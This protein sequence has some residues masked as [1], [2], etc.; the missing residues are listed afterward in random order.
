MKIDPLNLDLLYEYA[1]FLF[2]NLLFKEAITI[3]YKILALN[4][5]DGVAMEL[6]YKSY[7]KLNMLKETLDIGKQLLAEK[8]TDIFLLQE[9]AEIAGKLNNSGLETEYFNRILVIQPANTAALFNKA[10]NYLAEN[11]LEQATKIFTNLHKEGQND[12]ITTIYAGIG[13]VM[14]GNYTDAIKLL[15]PILSSEISDKT[16]INS[17]LGLLYLVYSLCQSSS[18]LSPIKRWAAKINYENLKQNYQP[19]D[20]QKVVFITEFIINQSLKVVQPSTNARD[21]IF[22][23]TKAYLPKGYFTTNSNSTIAELWF[24]IGNKQVDVKNLSDAVNSFQKAIDLRPNETK[25]QQKQSEIN[26][27]LEGAQNEKSKKMK[28]VLVVSFA[29]LAII[30]V[31]VFAFKFLQEK[32]LWNEAKSLNSTAGYTKYLSGYPN[33]KYSSEA[34]DSLGSQLLGLVF[35]KGGTFLMGSNDGGDNEKP[36]HTVTLSDFYICKY[37]VTQALWESIMGFNP[38]NFK[39]ANLPVE[40]VSWNDIQEFLNKLSKKTGKIFNLPTEAQWEYAAGGGANNRTKYAG[41]NSE[42]SLKDYAWI[43]DN[44]NNTTHPVG[45]KKPNGLGLYDMSGNVWE[46]CS[47][48]YGDNYYANSP[49]NNP[50]G[51]GTGSYRVLRGGGWNGFASDC[52]VS[53]RYGFSPDYRNSSFGFRLVRV[54]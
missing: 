43:S 46:R 14:D 32:A 3:S 24:A 39:G 41:T 23:L 36:V 51:V 6:L 42:N 28:K 54:S 13:K 2:N 1:Q 52:R 9:L 16:D 49:Q 5:N 40:N 8:P 4:E 29:A 15:T 19:L 11:N 45:S 26:E 31:S 35:I 20:E 7:S 21:Q 18:G 38:S 27:L 48:W 12:R 33:G 30:A 34:N 37:E 44:S 53:D 22:E 17:N 47:D 25:Y 50:Q 10:Q